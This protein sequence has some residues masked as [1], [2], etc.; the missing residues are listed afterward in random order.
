MTDPTSALAIHAAELDGTDDALGTVVAWC[1]VVGEDG[2]F[3]VWIGG[4][5]IQP[6]LTE[7]EAAH[8]LECRY[9]EWKREYWTQRWARSN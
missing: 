2:T 5:L 8:I 6:G 9:Q 3:D 1:E 7:D 4:D